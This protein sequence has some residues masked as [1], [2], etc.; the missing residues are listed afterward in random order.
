[1][2]LDLHDDV[3][4]HV[5]VDIGGGVEADEL[6]ER[7][8]LGAPVTPEVGGVVFELDRPVV[9]QVLLGGTPLIG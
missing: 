9:D 6:P 1:V 3:G 5:G 7:Q 4:E 8:G 2:E